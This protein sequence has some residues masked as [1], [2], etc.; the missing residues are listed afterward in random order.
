MKTLKEKDV[1]RIIREEWEKKVFKIAETAG[2]AFDAKIN[3]EKM[4]LISPELK[5]MHTKSGIRYTVDSVGPRDVILR[6][7]ENETFLVDKDTLEKEYHL[8]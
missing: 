2:I 7:P 5:V 8:D 1:I 4:P 6:T 3:G